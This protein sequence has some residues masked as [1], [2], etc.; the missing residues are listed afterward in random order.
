MLLAASDI[1]AAPVLIF[2]GLGVIIALL[3]HANKSRG[4]VLT[5][6]MILFMATAAMVVAAYV[7]YNENPSEDPR[8]KR[9]PKEPSF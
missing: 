8:P 4:W 6:L 9:D 3:G 2:M 7:A 5:G 1:P